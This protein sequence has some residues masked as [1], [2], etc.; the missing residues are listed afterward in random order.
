MTT[1]RQTVLWLLDE[2]D[3]MDKAA[4]DLDGQPK[5]DPPGSVRLMDQAWVDA[6][7]GADYLRQLA[8]A[9]RRTAAR[10]AR[11]TTT[12]KEHAE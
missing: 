1:A 9:H 5:P 4:A 6:R 12:T 7:L 8:A 11:Q 3:R 10:L 2:A